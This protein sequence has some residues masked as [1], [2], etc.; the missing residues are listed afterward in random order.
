M[1]VRVREQAQ[2]LTQLLPRCRDR[3]AE[4]GED[5]WTLNEK[6]WD[7]FL[8]IQFACHAIH[9]CKVDYLMVSSVFIEL[10][11]TRHN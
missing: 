2:M 7:S 1:K 6:L 3:P 8:E 4:S 9:P 11:I 5:G 10:D